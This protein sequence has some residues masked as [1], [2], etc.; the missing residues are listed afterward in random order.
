MAKREPTRKQILQM[1]RRF[2]I[3]PVDIGPMAQHLITPSTGVRVTGLPIDAE[4]ITAFYSPERQGLQMMY[5]HETFDK[6]PEGV[7]APFLEVS[8]TTYT[9]DNI[10]KQPASETT[11][12]NTTNRGQN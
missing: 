3:V 9:V 7:A 1:E 5:A 4:Y 8:Y 10:E 11:P 6:V 12:H 2:G